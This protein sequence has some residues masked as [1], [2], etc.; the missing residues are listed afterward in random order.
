MDL[1]KAGCESVWVISSGR[2]LWTM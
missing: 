1:I 2:F